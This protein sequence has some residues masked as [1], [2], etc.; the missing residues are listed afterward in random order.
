LCRRRT[1]ISW[2]KIGEG[3]ESRKG[4]MASGRRRWMVETKCGVLE[5]FL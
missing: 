4:M 2:D 5:S 1:S 3:M